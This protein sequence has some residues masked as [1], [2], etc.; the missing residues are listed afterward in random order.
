MWRYSLSS[1]A[2]DTHIV[3]F[4]LLS[5]FLILTSCQSLNNTDPTPE[6]ISA[7]SKNRLPT[8]T[9]IIEYQQTPIHKVSASHPISSPSPTLQPNTT[10]SLKST[11]TPISCSNDSGKIEKH[12]LYTPI[13][14]NPWHFRVYTPPC[15]D[16]D[17][18][19]HY[20]LLTLIH[21]STY[22]D[23]QWDRLGVDET[24]DELISS[25]KIAPFI[26]L[27]PRDRVWEEPT[28]DPFGQAVIEHILPWMALNYR[29]LPE[30]RFHAVGG[31]SRGASWAIH[32]GLSHWELFGAIGG[33]SPPVFWSD[34]P[35]IRRWL[36]EIPP[37]SLPRI[38]LDIGEKDYLIDS[39]LWFEGVLA[40]K[41]IPHEWYLFTGRHEEA[42]WQAHLEQYLRWYAINW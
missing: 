5:L 9:P 2:S 8:K 38:F 32:L 35:K 1:I 10:F 19:R 12:L 37:E 7:I 42:Y 25:K 28:E 15:Y 4:L 30:R 34:T 16:Q 17:I 11:P 3:S 14:P 13:A 41:G 6:V 33:H 31:L 36:D 27:M 23:E 40:E 26:I 20:P 18:D 39:A 21:G 22:T 29:I 24:A